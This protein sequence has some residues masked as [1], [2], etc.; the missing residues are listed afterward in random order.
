MI[1]SY[2][3]WTLDIRKENFVT[4]T[5]NILHDPRTY[6]SRKLWIYG[7][8]F[9][10]F[11]DVWRPASRG[12][13]SSNREVAFNFHCNRITID[14]QFVVVIGISGLHR[15]MGPHI[16]FFTCIDKIPTWPT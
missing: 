5:K 16:E 10:E 14:H 6:D 11:L 1:N 15:L 7:V 9:L 4:E 13:P 12:S 3:Y 2:Q 8:A